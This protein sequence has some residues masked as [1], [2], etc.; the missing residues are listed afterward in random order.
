MV[1]APAR[2]LHRGP[3]GTLRRPLPHA[4]RSGR[5][6]DAGLLDR[7]ADELLPGLQGGL[8]P[9]GGY[10]DFF[11]DPWEWLYHLIM[12]W[13]ALAI[14]FIGFY[15]RVLRS[16]VLDTINE[17]Y[18]RTARAKGLSE[19]RVLSHVLRNSLL[20]V[21]TLWGL[22]FGAV[23]GRSD[24]HRDG[25]RSPGCRPVRGRLDRSARRAA[26]SGHHDVRGVL[27]RGSTRSSTSS[28]R[29][30]TQGSGCNEASGG[31]P[32]LR[33]SMTSRSPSPQRKERFRRSTASPSNS[34]PARS[35]RWWGSRARA[36]PSPR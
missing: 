16:N 24:P 6:L 15:S 2:P 34:R 9:N 13:T 27:H 26:G 19:R 11:E 25:L 12:P 29:C 14:L 32:P 20:P 33:G 21:I 22:D 7:G 10:V 23:W 17:D 4:A 18:V 3:G 5:H 8:F 28:T 1:F 36:S 35:S 30:S 31:S